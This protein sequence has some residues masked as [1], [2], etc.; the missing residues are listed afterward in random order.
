MNGAQTMNKTRAPYRILHFVNVRTIGG[1]ERMF[2]DFLAH[3]PPFPVEHFTVANH[4]AVAPAIREA[5]F[6]YSQFFSICEF[7]G[8]RIPKRPHVLR[9][10]NRERLVR[11]LHPDLIL[12]W[13]QFLDVRAFSKSRWPCP[14]FYYEHGGAW[15]KQETSLVEAFFQRVD[16]VI[17]VSQAA[18]RTLQLK[19]RITQPID[20]CLNTLC[21]GVSS[22]KAPT[23]SRTL[24]SNRPLILGSAGRLVPVKCFGLLVLAIKALRAR[25]IE[26]EAIIAGTG[27]ERATLETLIAKQGLQEKVRLVGLLNDMSEFYQAIDVYISTAMHETLGLTCIEAAAWGVPAIA[28]AVDGLPEAVCHGMTGVCIKP[29]LSQEEYHALTQAPI[30]PLPLVYWP[31]IDSLAPP[32]MLAPEKIADAVVALLNDPARYQELSRQALAVSRER[33][34][35]SALCLNLYRIFDEQI[36]LRRGGYIAHTR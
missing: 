20:V 22:V 33:G 9:T 8:L 4:S 11:K 28:S 5:V 7:S 21:P 34:Q 18:K 30:D 32:K 3:A 29:T 31:D 17:A 23:E 13:N 35:F 26:A 16:G 15:Y 36:I 2:A 25:G 27:A 14:V 10:A 24:K 19:Y 6:R 1:V 12:I